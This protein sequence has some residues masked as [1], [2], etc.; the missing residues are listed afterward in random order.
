MQQITII[1]RFTQEKEIEKIYGQSFLFF[2]YADN[3]FSKIVRAIFS[4]IPFFSRFY[5]NL[6]QSKR[7]KKKILPFIKKYNVN[8][9]EFY[10]KVESFNSFNDFFIRKLKPD[11][12]PLS[13]N[14]QIAV[15]P[16]DGRY[17]VF[18]NIQT[19]DGFY[20]KGEKFSLEE[21]LQDKILAEKY[22]EGSMMIGRLAPVDYHRFHFPVDCI[23]QKPKLINGYLYSVNPIALKT[24]INI[25]SQNKRM[26][27]VLDTKNF[28]EILY[29]EVGASNVGTII[30]TF[31]AETEY[32]KGDEKG[33]FSFGGSSVVLLFEK[34]KIRFDEDLIKNSENKIE[35]KTT[36]GGS[37]GR[38]L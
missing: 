34:D 10:D 5:G 20:V 15:L 33:Y 30:Q 9:L 23:P 24:N 1:D 3:I 25:F 11:V 7:S 17:M 28:G 27:T 32:K 19:V 4:K 16:V 37:L 22:R 2:L 38:I 13:S 12:R 36:Y 29:I 26:L 14:P 21:F 6:Q 35:T 8:T 18:Q 31:F